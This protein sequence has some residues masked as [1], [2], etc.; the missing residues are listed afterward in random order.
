ML[1]IIRKGDSVPSHLLVAIEA[2]D[3]PAGTYV[4]DIL[5]QQSMGALRLLL[6]IKSR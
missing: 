1:Y 5:R 4:A 3:W 2:I 6:H